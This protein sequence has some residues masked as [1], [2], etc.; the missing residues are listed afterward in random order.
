MSLFST[1]DTK[2]LLS[3]SNYTILHVNARSLRKNYDS[4][5]HLSTHSVILFHSYVS[6]KPG[7]EPLMAAYMIFPLTILNI[8][9][10]SPVATAVQLFA[11][12]QQLTM[13][14]GLI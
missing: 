4:I 12:H 1:E 3:D 11:F 5:A 2:A 13:N 8:A 9:T 14:E 6:P 10:A 7:L